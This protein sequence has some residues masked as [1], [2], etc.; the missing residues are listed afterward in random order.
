MKVVGLNVI[1]STLIFTVG[2]KEYLRRQRTMSNQPEANL[3][4]D[5]AQSRF[6]ELDDFISSKKAE[7]DS[8][9]NEKE[10]IKAYLVKMGEI[11]EER[12]YKTSKGM[13]KGHRGRKA[14]AEAVDK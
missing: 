4:I 12:S 14:K 1:V 3:M 11:R 2:E 10:A 7:I 8:Y 6:K 5:T 13:G 9:E